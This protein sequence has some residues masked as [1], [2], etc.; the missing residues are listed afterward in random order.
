MKANVQGVRNE[1]L[2]RSE[3]LKALQP[4]LDLV[5]L[6]GGQVQEITVTPTNIRVRF[7]ARDSRTKRL[8][9]NARVSVSHK[10]V[11]DD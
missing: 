4:L 3:L 11:A 1:P 6:D 7:L 2:G 8:V 9:H 5:D 10:V